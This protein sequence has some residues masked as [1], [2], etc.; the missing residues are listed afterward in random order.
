MHDPTTVAFEIHYP[1]H[2]RFWQT[3]AQYTSDKQRKYNDPFITIWHNDPETDGSDDSCGWFMRSKHGNKEVLEKII[4]EFKFNWDSNFT[5]TNNHTYYTGYF[6]SDGKINMSIHGIVLDLFFRAAYIVFKYNRRKMDKYMNKN[7]ARILGFA[8]NPIDS[9]HTSLTRKF[10]NA[11]GEEYNE[12][13]K[14]EWIERTASIVYGYILRDIRPWYKH[15][16]WHVHHWSFQ[17]HPLQEI[18][19]YLFDRCAICKK[20]FKWNACVIGNWDGDKIWHSVCDEKLRP[21]KFPVIGEKLV[22]QNQANNV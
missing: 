7:L 20:G 4:K 11:C 9:M 21:Q 22:E 3:E 5:S 2:K 10:E 16:R 13:I 17:I 19:R 14:Q 1:W 15:P 6:T 12:K 18:K 8:E